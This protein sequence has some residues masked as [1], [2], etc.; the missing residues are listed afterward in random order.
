[1][2]QDKQ[3]NLADFNQGVS[4]ALIAI[5]SVN[6]SVQL[7][8]RSLGSTG[9]WFFGWMYFVG[10]MLQ[11]WYYQA[12]S[13]FS[14]SEDFVTWEAFAAVN[15]IWFSI[16]GVVRAFHKTRR[17]PSHSYDPGVGILQSVFPSWSAGTVAVASDLTVAVF[18]SI[19]LRMIE[20]PILSGWYAAMSFWLLVGHVWMRTSR[21]YRYQ[22]YINTK[23]EA[24][25]WSN[26]IKER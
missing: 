6:R 7:W 11:A 19:V 9:G 12:N 25:Q 24:E 22:V 26:Q 15:I 20:S 4:L 10:L 2:Q 1:M 3:Q 8:S 14:G 5:F 13:H 16:H 18:L 23:A 21:A 17:V